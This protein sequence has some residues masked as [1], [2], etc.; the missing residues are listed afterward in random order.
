MTF[1]YGTQLNNLVTLKAKEGSAVGAISVMHGNEFDG[2]ALPDMKVVDGKLDP[3]ESYG[4]KYA[5]SNEKKP[6]AITV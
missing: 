6:P 1:R 3:M 2:M 4:S 5:G